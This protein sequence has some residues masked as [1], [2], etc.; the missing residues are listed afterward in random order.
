MIGKFYH[1]HHDDYQIKGNCRRWI[2]RVL[3][4]KNRVESLDKKEVLKAFKRANDGK[5]LYLPQQDMILE[6]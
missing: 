2:G 5:K 4:I 1:P 3:N 6:I